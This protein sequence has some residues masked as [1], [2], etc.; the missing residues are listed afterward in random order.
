M[1]I[2][3][4]GSDGGPKIRALKIERSQASSTD[5]DEN[6][7]RQKNRRGFSKCKTI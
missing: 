7:R 1:V 5:V 3:I 2:S 6:Q 4:I